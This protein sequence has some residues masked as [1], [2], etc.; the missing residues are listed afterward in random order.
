M[1]HPRPEA[2]NLLAVLC[3]LALGAALG[4]WA[5]AMVVMGGGG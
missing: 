4:A 5:A 1:T 3:A 2:L